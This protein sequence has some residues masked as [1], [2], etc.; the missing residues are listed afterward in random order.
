VCT[1]VR[2]YA[3]GLSGGIVHHFGSF[4]TKLLVTP[5]RCE[6]LARWRQTNF[7]KSHTGSEGGRGG[8]PSAVDALALVTGSFAPLPMV[9][10]PCRSNDSWVAF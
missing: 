1:L 2:W 6:W 3:G 7:G 8:A 10:S 9:G 4:Q 5:N